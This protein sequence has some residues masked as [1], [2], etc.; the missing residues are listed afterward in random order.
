M[1]GRGH[2]RGHDHG[3]VSAHDDGGAHDL[4][5][6]CAR[7]HARGDGE[8]ALLPPQVSSHDD[9]LANNANAANRCRNRPHWVF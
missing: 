2:A 4:A 7:D 1:N 9:D 8:W 3:R 5:H 6:G